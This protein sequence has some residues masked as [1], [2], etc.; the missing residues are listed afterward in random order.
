[1]VLAPETARLLLADHA[2]P[3]LEVA[4][5][6]VFEDETALRP[7]TVFYSAAALA[8]PASPTFQRPYEPSQFF[9]IL[10]VPSSD[11]DAYSLLSG[12]KTTDQIGPWWP[13]CVSAPRQ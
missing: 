7:P 5:S 8:S 1:M 11:P 6:A 4:L 10:I 3:P 9:H 13:F 2:E 12:E